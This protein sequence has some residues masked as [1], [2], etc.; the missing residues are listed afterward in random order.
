MPTKRWPKISGRLRK[1]SIIRWNRR[2]AMS[3]TIIYTDAMKEHIRLQKE[4][5]AQ[6]QQRDSTSALKLYGI[7]F[8]PLF[9]WA[10]MTS[11]ASVSVPVV[12]T[13]APVIKPLPTALTPVAK[14]SVVVPATIM[15]AAKGTNPNY[16]KGI[17][18]QT[19]CQRC[20]VTYELRRRGMDVTAAPNYERFTNVFPH[21]TN[22]FT[23]F[24]RH[25]TRGNGQYVSRRVLME[26]I[27]SMPNGARGI[28]S[29]SFKGDDG[30]PDGHVI[31]F[32]KY[33]GRI[34]FI[35][36]QV[37]LVGSSALGK[38]D[39][40]GYDYARLDNLQLTGRL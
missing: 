40:N 11:P 31:N 14:P 3:S 15:R 24:N 33:N 39:R 9:T 27:G 28:V 26:R 18:F 8:I 6:E 34:I 38:A 36:P 35:D 5:E 4:K 12:S 17:E 23:S 30:M 19:N 22:V 29:W 16:Y 21:L 7:F 13:P 2:C 20:V 37:G 10:Y 32:E 1:P 25:G